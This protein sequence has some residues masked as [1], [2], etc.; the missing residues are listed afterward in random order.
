MVLLIAI[1]VVTIAAAVAM[2]RWL[3]SRPGMGI[4]LI[5]GAALWIT[6]IASGLG[7]NIPRRDKLQASGLNFGRKS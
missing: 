4:V 6:T 2:V 7:E 5:L 3:D 1:P